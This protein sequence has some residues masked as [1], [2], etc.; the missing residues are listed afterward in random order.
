MGPCVF[1]KFAA[2]LDLGQDLVSL[3]PYQ[4]RQTTNVPLRGT[5]RSAAV[6]ALDV[7]GEAG[8]GSFRRLYRGRKVPHT[9]VAELDAET[10]RYHFAI[11]GNVYCPDLLDLLPGLTFRANIPP[12]PYPVAKAPAWMVRLVA[13][14]VPRSSSI[15]ELNR[16]GDVLALT[17]EMIRRFPP[18]ESGEPRAV[19]SRPL[20][21]L[22]GRE[23]REDVIVKALAGWWEHY[24]AT[25][26]I[27]VD[28][29]LAYAEILKGIDVRLKHGTLLPAKALDH[30]ELC[31][32]MPRPDLPPIGRTRMERI[33]VESVAVHFLHRRD[34]CGETAENFAMSRDF[35]REVMRVRHGEYPSN[36][37]YQRLV[38][39]Y[40]SRPGIPATECEIAER[41]SRGRTG[42]ASRYRS[43][44]FAEIFRLNPS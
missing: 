24:H 4:G 8:L 34:H 27:D 7:A 3:K 2:Q 35:V 30:V 38:D 11:P 18:V 15:L 36:A 41:I 1:A 9:D 6:I 28:P 22:L 39:K 10:Y 21:S 17:A 5:Q 13:D 31:R 40:L 19:L 12:T 37:T 26:M 14:K 29:S 44:F 25:G 16:D 42:V 20:A 33:F 23:F 43:R 32:A